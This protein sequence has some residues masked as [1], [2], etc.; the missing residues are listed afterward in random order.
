MKNIAILGSTGSIGKSTLDVIR[1]F[2]E[3]FK[4]VALTTNSNIDVLAQQIKEFHPL[5]VGVADRTS[6]GKLSSVLSRKIKLFSAQD[7]IAALAGQKEIDEVV[8][9]IS[10][11]AA[12]MPLLSA[13]RSAKTV[14]LAN[15]EALVM[16]GPLIM[17]EA[18]KNN[19]KI[20]PVDSEQSAI[21]Q[22][23]EKE[24]KAKLKGIYLTASGGPLLKVDNRRLKA[25]RVKDVLRHPRWK[26]GR[27]ITVDSATLMNKGLELLEAM[28]L[29][30]V[31]LEKIK[32]LIHPEAIIHSMVEFVD[33]VVM[34]Q[35]SVTDMRIPIQYALSY[36]DRLENDFA[37][38]DFY[39]LGV[40]HFEKPSLRRFPCLG[41]AVQ[42]AR[43][44]G[45][46]PAVMN[47]ANEV[48]VDEFLRKRLE[49]IA[50]SKVVAKVMDE[51]KNISRPSLDEIIT[52][53]SWARKEAYKLCHC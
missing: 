7:G 13:I 36:P 4:V 20:I 24:D 51:H 43:E 12:L 9:A 17:R 16:A 53:D 35:L 31:P 1:K 22:C 48:S 27:K 8:L 5:F 32:I 29:F 47:A 18:Q 23:I 6:V 15:K 38:I 14:A 37:G 28:F 19:V 39:R 30:Q 21:W 11:S 42:A 2:P 34:A 25:I 10:G 50:I 49:F 52:A 46:L 40:L 41:L 33:G 45:T 3:E 26:M 44:L